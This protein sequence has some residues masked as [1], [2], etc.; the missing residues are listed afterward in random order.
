MFIARNDLL[1]ANPDR[2]SYGVAVTDIDGDG[3]YEFVVTGF[4]GTF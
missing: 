1:Y 2:M 4:G 3:L